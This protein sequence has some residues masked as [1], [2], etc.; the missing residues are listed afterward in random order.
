MSSVNSRV[1]FVEAVPGQIPGQP[2]VKI[3]VGRTGRV[4]EVLNGGIV[5]KVIIPGHVV[6]VPT[7][8][9]ENF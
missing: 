5:L 1:R 6:Y 2:S 9:T 3:P 4:I 7:Y 8:A